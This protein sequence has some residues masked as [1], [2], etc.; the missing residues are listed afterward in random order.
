MKTAKDYQ[1]KAA[2]KMSKSI[3]FAAILACLIMA[4]AGSAMAATNQVLRNLN[5][6]IFDGECCVSFNESVSISEPAT[7]EPAVVIWSSGYGIEVPDVYKAG[8]SVNGGP[9][10]VGVWGPAA[11]PDYEL[12]PGGN[13]LHVDFQWIIL[14]SDDVL[15][16][17][18]NTFELCG[19]GTNS[20]SDSIAIYD[21]TLSVQL[22]K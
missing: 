9:C 19:G 12:G 15:V 18:V 1:V 4:G 6:Q 7:L 11:I 22:V 3:V 2:S 5:E 13:Y 17:G 10:E 14:P 8:L 21:N 20:S 16:K